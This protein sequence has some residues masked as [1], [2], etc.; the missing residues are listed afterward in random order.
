[1]TH[2]HR[3]AAKGRYYT[4]ERL[5]RKVMDLLESKG[6]SRLWNVSVEPLEEPEEQKEGQKVRL[7]GIRT[8]AE[9][10]IGR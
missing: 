4:R 7:E 8:E 3:I 5:H 10:L 9:T 2:L 1:M 6:L